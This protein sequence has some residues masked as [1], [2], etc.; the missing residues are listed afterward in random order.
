V[1]VVSVALAQTGHPGKGTWLGHYG[2][3][4]DVQRRI[5]L[6]LDWRDQKLS[7]V[8]NPGPRSTPI[9]TAEI[10][11]ATWTMTVEADIAAQPGEPTKKWRGVGKMENLGSW[12]NRRYSGTY[13]HGTETGSFTF[14]LN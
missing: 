8:A 4:K 14:T 1:T 9:K 3:N 6:L 11:F 7:G 5:V 12:T 13:T 2:P 10:D